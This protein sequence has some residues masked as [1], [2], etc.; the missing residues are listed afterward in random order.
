[1]LFFSKRS[2]GTARGTD[3]TRLTAL[4]GYG[5]RCSRA[6]DAVGT[7]GPFSTEAKESGPKNPHH[8]LL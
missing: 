7:A 8:L 4:S 6:V 5:Q 3:A 1:M 2:P